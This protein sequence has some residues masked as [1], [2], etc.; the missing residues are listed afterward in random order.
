MDFSSRPTKRLG[1][2]K[3]SRMAMTSAY[4]PV[5]SAMAQPMIIVVVTLPL[6]SG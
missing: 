6:L 4:R 3:I 2:T 5:V 1:A